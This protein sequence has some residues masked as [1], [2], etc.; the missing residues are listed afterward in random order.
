MALN[1][2]KH[3]P[4]GRFAAT[5]SVCKSPTPIE[6]LSPCLIPVL[7]PDPSTMSLGSGL[8]GVRSDASIS[9]RNHYPATYSSIPA[10]STPLPSP[11]DTL[12]SIALATSPTFRSASHYQ[13]PNMNSVARTH[14]PSPVINSIPTL[15]KSGQD[16]PST[17]SFPRPPSILPSTD[18]AYGCSDT[19]YRSL[20]HLASTSSDLSS[21]PDMSTDA[22]SEAVVISHILLSLHN[23]NRTNP[24]CDD[25]ATR[26]RHSPQSSLHLPSA[27]SQPHPSSVD[28]YRKPFHVDSSLDHGRNHTALNS[29]ASIP[30]DSGASLPELSFSTSRNK[31]PVYPQ[32][33][34]IPL[35]SQSNHRNSDSQLLSLTSHHPVS[36]PDL[37]KSS[38][39]P[40]STIVH[41]QP[42]CE[43]LFFHS[44][45]PQK[46]TTATVEISNPFSSSPVLSFRRPSSTRMDKTVRVPD[47]TPAKVD[48]AGDADGEKT[49][50]CAECKQVN[51]QG[52]R[53]TGLWVEC[54]GC[55]L[56]FH[57][58]CAGFKSARELRTVDNFYC[59]S[60]QPTFGP[61]T[62]VWK[63]GRPKP[64]VDYA[65]LNDGI[66]KPSEHQEQLEHQYVKRIKEGGFQFLPDS[67]PRLRPECATSDYIERCS[68]FKEPVLI[69]A[70]WNPRPI[71]PGTRRSDDSHTLDSPARPVETEADIED[72]FEYEYCV[73]E[74]Q[75]MIGMVIPEG[76]TVRRVAELY[77][78][79]EKLDVIDVKSQ[80][81]DKRWTLDQWAEYYHSHEG[82]P[83][84]NVISL[85]VSWSKLGRLIRRPQFVRDLDLQDDVWPT[86]EPAPK[87]Q[88]Y[89]LMSVADSYTDFHIDFGGS[90][91]YYHIVKGRKT[92]F[93][94]PP[95]KQNLKKYEEW[96]I[97][98]NQNW[99]W[100][101]DLVDGE[102]YRMDLYQGD[103]AF[104]PSG[105]IHAV[106]TPEDSLVIGGNFLTRLSFKMQFAVSDVEKATGVPRKFRYPHFQ[107]VH[108]YT[109]L[110]Y[111]EADP[112][113]DSVAALLESGQVF[114]RDVPVYLQPH[115]FGHNS[116]PGP[117]NYNARYYAKSEILDL[118][119][120]LQ[121]LFRS[122]MISSAHL[123]GVTADTKAAV[124]RAIP[125]VK[126][127]SNPFLTVQKLAQW[128]CW[129]R[130]N[131]RIPQWA[132]TAWVLEDAIIEAGGDP[133]GKRVTRV[134]LDRFNEPVPE[135]IP[136][137]DLDSGAA[138]PVK[139]APTVPAFSDVTGRPPVAVP[140]KQEA[141]SDLLE[142]DSMETIRSISMDHTNCQAK[143]EDEDD[144]GELTP[145]DVISSAVDASPPSKRPN[146]GPRRF[147]CDTCRQR[148]IR[149]R[150]RNQAPSVHVSNENI[151]E[152]ILFTPRVTKTHPVVDIISPLHNISPNA[153]STVSPTA[154]DAKK[155][156][157]R[158]CASCR[159]S[160]V[161]FFSD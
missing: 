90:S 140:V 82:K 3:D 132:H 38:A 35:T 89:C 97:S 96:N 139:P 68:G 84:R 32:P 43:E 148:R 155:T 69:P 54:S 11:I 53:D 133:K 107:K 95:S 24:P 7:G 56:W 23:G 142:P 99:T 105:W 134:M 47:P 121:Y 150:H 59:H 51:Y 62:Y 117:E 103:T 73:D 153:Q 116:M 114:E 36:L 154:S 71:I 83:V 91:V 58:P 100:F 119:E 123:E 108:W 88:L 149:C 27:S 135:Y 98:P 79:S 42:S 151:P 33:E 156:R 158:A 87:V 25:Q 22:D 111:L 74:G 66:A 77:G 46:R 136:K 161:S 141:V 159:V 146:I 128:I 63:P 93:F 57:C 30:A 85:E 64:A 61:T 37:T 127:N 144:E 18:S 92:F 80:S 15:S 130:G 45:L 31:T 86:D 129:K 4:A 55:S 21:S 52:P 2:L 102:C 81:A 143:E 145:M 120:F 60:C 6:P 106:W 72:I 160:K 65:Q 152:R 94:V 112:L 49:A 70:A 124:S 115:H 75:D 41:P 40:S 16:R 12:A 34:H 29:F 19:D 10:R 1:S 44:S 113:P 26:T 104:I 48:P 76:L 147:A 131:E 28:Q 67:F 13:I 8:N 118:P 110:R 39:S 109:A 9:S 157:H 126:A 5:P 50:T 20:P 17:T 78:P 125:K 101:P 14:F 137:P 122:V 138:L